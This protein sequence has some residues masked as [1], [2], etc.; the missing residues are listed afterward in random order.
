MKNIF[1]KLSILTAIY[2]ASSISSAGLFGDPE[3]TSN[4][5]LED[6][7]PLI[8]TKQAQI[9]QSDGF[10]IDEG[11]IFYIQPNGPVKYV[12]GTKKIQKIIL[13][14]DKLISL[15]KHGVVSILS[16]DKAFG[17]GEWSTIGKHT[18][19]I[20]TD[21]TDLFA[22]TYEKKWLSQ[23]EIRS[24]WTYK[25]EPGQLIWTYIPIMTPYFCGGVVNCFNTIYV[26]AISGREIAF[27]DLHVDGAQYFEFTNNKLF[28]I[29]TEEEKIILTRPPEQK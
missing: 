27:T 6:L 13:F 26:P 22:L 18:T 25:G 2:F 28:I 19:D 10:V 11:H 15:D 4:Y 7:A 21:G 29:T 9:R 5:T 24:V 20:E 3:P 1:V 23:R 17:E 14:K 16:E 8:S 12:L